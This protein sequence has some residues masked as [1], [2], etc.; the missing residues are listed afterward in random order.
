[1]TPKSFSEPLLLQ[2]LL[3]HPGGKQFLCSH[4]TYSSIIQSN[5]STARLHFMSAFFFPKQH[6]IPI[7]QQYLEFPVHTKGD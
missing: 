6:K 4:L 5:T 1:M 2:A 3:S 7:A